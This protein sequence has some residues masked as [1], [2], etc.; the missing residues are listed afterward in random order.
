MICVDK[1]TFKI[2]LML[3][4]LLFESCH[5]QKFK[6]E[7]CESVVFNISN[8]YA[9][10]DSVSFSDYDFIS[11][12]NK[13][14]CMLGS[15]DKMCITPKGIYILDNRVHDAIFLFEHNGKFIRKIG[16]QGHAKNEYVK[17]D[18]FTVNEN[19]DTIYLLDFDKVKTYTSENQF[20]NT[21]ELDDEYGWDDL[22]CIDG[23]VYMG[24]YHHGYS[25]ILTKYSD[26]FTQK[27]QIGSMDASLVS[28]AAD[29]YRF[30]QYNEK[31]ICFFDYVN[32]SIY[33]IDR[34]SQ[35][36]AKRY[37]IKMDAT[38]DNKGTNA[39]VM[40][41]M[42]EILNVLLTD[43]YLLCLLSYQGILT[44]YTIDI[45]GDC[46]CQQ[47]ETLLSH[48]L[49]GFYN[50]YVYKWYS[51]NALVKMLDSNNDKLKKAIAPFKEQISEDDNVYL[52]RMK[53]SRSFKAGSLN[54]SGS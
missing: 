42:N 38:S 36:P 28:A 22:A 51:A 34:K 7:E 50:G 2:T 26:N 46:L 21:Y 10:N 11:L 25:G 6:G 15:I 45:N 1:N 40:P 14:E 39:G 53:L 30:I 9:Y 31:Y 13:N 17:I 8:N 49:C 44:S 4:I 12:E 37:V 35:T 16:I 29:N 33:L 5:G 3:S 32:S 24:S 20:V 19:G 41:S 27:R 52:M 48:N 54:E 47:E 18:N 23:Y 43:N